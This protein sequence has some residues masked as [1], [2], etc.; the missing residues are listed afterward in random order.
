M[1]LC[2]YDDFPTVFV[3]D[4]AADSSHA[5]LTVMDQLG[6]IVS[7]DPAKVFD[8]AEVFDVLGVRVDLSRFAAGLVLVGNKPSRLQECTDLVERAL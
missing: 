7:T 2:Y 5:F 8:F 1:S 6:W 3:P 4:L